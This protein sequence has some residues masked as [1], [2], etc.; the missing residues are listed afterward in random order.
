MR[1]PSLAAAAL[2]A[3]FAVA[4]TACTAPPGAAVDGGSHDAAEG[5][6]DAGRPATDGAR[7]DAHD[8]GAPGDGATPSHGGPGCGLASAAFCDTFDAPA[9]VQGRAG[10]LDARWWSGGRLAPQGPTTSGEAFDVAGATLRPTR[11]IDGGTS[12]QLPACRAGLPTQVSPDQDTL[13]CD[14]SVDI[15]SPHLLV[16]VAAQN[17]GA[18]SYR[19]RQPFDFAGRTGK[20]EFDAE[21]LGGGLLGWVS[22]EVTEDPIAVPGFSIG[23]GPSPFPNDEGTPL[24]RNGFELQLNGTEAGG[25]LSLFATFENYLET[26]SNPDLVP[27]ATGWG[28][29]NHFEVDISESRIDLY[30]SP[31]SSDGKTFAPKQQ[32]FTQSVA[33]G[34]S[35]GYVH[36]T[37]H[38]HATLKY[39]APGLG[40]GDGFKNL[41]SWIARWDNVGF[42]GPT[43][44]GWRE[45]EVS[46]A[47]V[48]FTLTVGGDLAVGTKVT[49]LGWT[50]P[51]QATGTTT[52]LHLRGVDT[53]GMTRAR[54]ALTSW[55][56][57]GCGGTPATFDL[58]FR[59]NGGT[60][61][62]RPLDPGELAYLTGGACQGSLAQMLDVAMSE[63]VPGDNLLE[64]NTANV[65][66]SYPPGVTNVDLVLSA[67]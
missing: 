9:T 67:D 5:E 2:L 18:N 16:A 33:L 53:T 7:T 25:I 28:K 32:V 6:R 49:N 17:Y 23:Q 42:D 62:D 57:L 35:R 41:D 63:L 20:I 30:A 43:I 65:P 52:A 37:T 15:A 26:D 54:V 50:L 11:A 66:Q 36:V 48:P 10:E 3:V 13:I 46:D 39:S 21:A 61:H 22:L 31:A 27:L 4:A 40:F 59:L 64:L 12:A 55:Y 47:E 14:P 56:C 58:R 1:S 24:P 8:A 34:F 44:G 19:I 38:N 29:L 45:Y 60:W 51:D